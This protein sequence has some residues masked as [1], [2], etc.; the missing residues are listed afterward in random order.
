MT[1]GIDFKGVR[2]VINYDLPTTVQGY[3]H[4]VGRTGGSTLLPSANL[5]SVL[6]PVM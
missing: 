1:R 6:D 3:V 2:T 5:L 4:R